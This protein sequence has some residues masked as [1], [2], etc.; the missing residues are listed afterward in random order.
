MTVVAPLGIAA[1]ASIK[2]F[3]QFGLG[4]KIWIW[5]SWA[6]AAVA[7]LCLPFSGFFAR[8]PF[9]DRDIGSILNTYREMRWE[10]G[11]SLIPTVLLF[12]S[13]ILVWASQSGNGGAL[14]QVAPILPDLPNKSRIS[15]ARAAVIQSIGRPLPSLRVAAWLWAVWGIF[16]GLMLWAHVHFRPFLEITTLES[17]GTTNLIRSLAATIGTLIFLD[18]LQFF[19]LWNEL[20]GLLQALDREEIRRSFVPIHDFNWRNLWSITG[21]SLSDR[22]AILSAQVSCVDDLKGENGFAEPAAMVETLHNKYGETDLS[23]VDCETYRSD[24]M[25]GY[26]A[27]AVAAAAAFALIESRKNAV[28]QTGISPDADAIQRVLACQCKGDGGRFSD[29]AEEL[30]RLP[31]WQQTAEKL[32]C[33]LYIG[34]IQTIVARL[35]TL[36]VSVASMFSLVTLGLAIYPFAPFY[37]LLITG[38]LFLALIGWA[39]FKVFSEMD[40]DPILSRIVNGDDRKLQGNF[41]MRFAEAIALPLLT[42]GSSIL[43]GG[44]GRLLELAQSIFSHAQ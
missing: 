15:N 5:I 43:P 17:R 27:M 32:I 10:S 4:W 24:L 21:T 3:T 30:A 13:A 2:V 20:H 35:H 44:A 16:A 22:R 25:E 14:F 11:L 18:V 42:L 33:L 8:D 31:Q 23:H 37:P 6:P 40:T 29:E 7:G 41:Y 34:F 36:L 39:F 28:A 12:L 19:A 38:L 1:S 26:G 9:A